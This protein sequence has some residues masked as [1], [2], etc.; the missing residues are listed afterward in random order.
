MTKTTDG[1][2]D[3]APAPTKPRYR[4]IVRSWGPEKSGKNHFGFTMPGPIAGLYRD[5]GGTEGV[6]EKFA[7]APFGPKEIRQ[8]YYPFKKDTFTQAQACEVR[9]AF[10][11]DFRRMLKVAR[12]I[13]FD[14]AETWEVFRYAEFGAKSD[15]PRNYDELNGRYLN[16]LQ[17]AYDSGVNLHCIQ[18][19]TQVWGED[20]RGKPKPTGE[21]RA[22][23]MK[24]LRYLVQVNIEHSWT[25][26]TGFVCR[27]DNCR[28]NMQLAG[29]E[30]PALDFPTL[31]QLVFPDSEA[32][33]WE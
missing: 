21:Y 17:E 33:D 1:W 9:D 25:K 22:T 28:Q 19:V 32:S 4:M 26:E 27:V 24:E 3:F 6:V 20:S 10:I 5:P 16:L 18:K 13:Q 2:G 14:E 11:G 8:K 23:G 31:G 12:S 15:A 7:V 29:E 30:Y